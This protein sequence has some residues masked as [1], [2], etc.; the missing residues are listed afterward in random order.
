MN[1]V[2]NNKYVETY[3]TNIFCCN[4]LENTNKN[5]NNDIEMRS[6]T[7]NPPIII[8]ENTKNMI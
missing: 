7:Q 1:L 3:I 6:V 4:K 5:D 8:K 2:H